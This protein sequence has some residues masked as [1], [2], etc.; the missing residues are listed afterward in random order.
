MRKFKVYHLSIG[1]DS[2]DSKYD[3]IEIDLPLYEEEVD[4]I[5]SGGIRGIGKEHFAD[6]WELI[7]C[8]APQAF[9]RALALADEKSN[10]EFSKSN[11][12][13]H[14]IAIFLPDDI[15]DRIW[16][17]SVALEFERTKK[18]YHDI[19]NAIWKRDRDIL[20][21]NIAQGRWDDKIA[22]RT[23]QDGIWSSGGYFSDGWLDVILVNDIKTSYG[24]KYYFREKRIEL[25]IYVYGIG[26]DFLKHFCAFHQKNHSFPF[27]VEPISWYARIL[28]ETDISNHGV[29]LFMNFLDELTHYE[30]QEE[31]QNH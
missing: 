13:Y 12:K 9:K 1:A 17:S 18:E 5:V 10:G 20:L 22:N 26:V 8:F 28:T 16:Q 31:R 24:K 3:D 30:F 23:L 15:S 27:K 6:D 14:D 21:S 25:Q 4:A 2:L 19:S 11:K 7:E 29:E